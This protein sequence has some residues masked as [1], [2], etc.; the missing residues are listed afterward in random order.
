M[1]AGIPGTGIGGLFYIVAALLAPLR[2]PWQRNPT[3]I[4]LLLLAAGVLVGI[5]ATGWLL[6]FVL[7]PAA[8]APVDAPAGWASHAAVVNVVRWAA[9]FASF[10]MLGAVLLAV[11]VLRLVWRKK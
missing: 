2:K 1:T 9:L 4:T 5:F 10:M 8:P 7:G 11:Q 3:S 6:G